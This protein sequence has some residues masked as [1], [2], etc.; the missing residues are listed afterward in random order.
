MELFRYEKDEE[1]AISEIV[2]SER[3][4][5]SLDGFFIHF[6][7]SFQDRGQITRHELSFYGRLCRQRLLFRGDSH[8]VGLVK[9][10]TGKTT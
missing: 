6:P 10:K 9:G 4:L 8:A 3:W 7:P 1:K 5:F 2:I